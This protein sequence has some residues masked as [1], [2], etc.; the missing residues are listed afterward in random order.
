[1]VKLKQCP[2]NINGISALQWLHSLFGPLYWGKKILPPVTA[3]GARLSAAA[4][5][6][7][8]ALA[9]AWEFQEIW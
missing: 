6:H 4:V 1:M 5:F 8:G 3:V 2:P 7:E 9:T